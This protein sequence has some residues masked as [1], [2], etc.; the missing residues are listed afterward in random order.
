MCFSFAINLLQKAGAVFMP[1]THDRVV[2]DNLH[3]QQF[4]NSLTGSLI[5]RTL[6]R[7]I[8]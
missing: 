6:Q 3:I 1:T 5:N 2:N 4:G 8:T 7:N